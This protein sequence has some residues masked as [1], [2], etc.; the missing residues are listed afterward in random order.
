MSDPG[1][2]AA[3]RRRRGVSSV[4][5]IIVMVSVAI[6]VL[7]TYRAFGTRFR[8]IVERATGLF[9]GSDGKLSAACS[10]R[11]RRRRR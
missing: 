11:Q 8:C 1:G 4:E 10:R 2:S 5:Y 9:P 7:I 6:S 3:R